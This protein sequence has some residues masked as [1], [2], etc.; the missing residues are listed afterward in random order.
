MK[1]TIEELYEKAQ[2]EN[3]S[4][5]LYDIS[6]EL[7]DLSYEYQ[8]QRRTISPDLPFNEKHSRDCELE[9]LEA[10]ADLKAYEVFQWADEMEAEE[11]IDRAMADEAGQH[12]YYR[13]GMSQGISRA[14]MGVR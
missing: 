5:A 12:A 8:Q 11:L 6:D 7:N 3:L 9:T 2:N 13:E 1:H 10:E 14:N 4:Q